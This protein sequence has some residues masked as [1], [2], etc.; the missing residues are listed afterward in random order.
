MDDTRTQYLKN[1]INGTNAFQAAC[2][3]LK[4]VEATAKQTSGFR[5]PEEVQSEIASA[6]STVKERY[7]SL[8]KVYLLWSKE[9]LPPL[10][11]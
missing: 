8:Q 9:P 7:A 6:S 3:N 1:L 10:A 4:L 5:N 11:V 2:D